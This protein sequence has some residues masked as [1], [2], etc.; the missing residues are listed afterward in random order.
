MN[1]IS[2]EIE[3]SLKSIYGDKW[4]QGF[5]AHILIG[6]GR[7]IAARE[8]DGQPKKKHDTIEKLEQ[9][10]LGFVRLRDERLANVLT[11]RIYAIRL[12]TSRREVSQDSPNI[13]DLIETVGVWI[14]QRLA[15]KEN[16][17]LSSTLE[18]LQQVVWKKAPLTD[19]EYTLT[20]VRLLC[21]FS[22]SIHI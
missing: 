4:R 18:A 17:V 8:N 13:G 6:L 7:I 3:D 2:R 20:V 14:V 12:R 22:L 9:N 1:Q 10:P 19:K 5:L 16:K 21:L 15:G 11:T